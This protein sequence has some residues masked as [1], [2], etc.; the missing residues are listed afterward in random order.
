MTLRGKR[1]DRG[2]REKDAKSAHSGAIS[3]TED[4]P[5]RRPAGSGG[6][7]AGRENLLAM[8]AAERYNRYLSSLL[9]A[10]VPAG[11]AGA[12]VLDFGAGLGLFARRLREEGLEVECLEP[13]DEYRA[14]LAADGFAVRTDLASLGPG[15]DLIYAV[16]VLEHAE[17][18]ERAFRALAERLSPGGRLLV[19]VP[20]FALLFSGM[21]RAVGH[22]RRYRAGTLRRYA[23]GAGLAVSVCRY[24]DPLGFPTALLYRV[25]GR[26]SGVLSSDSLRLYDQ[27]VFRW[28]ARLEPLTGRFFGKNLLL[29]AHKR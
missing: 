26:K 21:D 24:C 28:S 12:R 5:S 2:G 16:N 13:D 15:Y 9:L 25:A 18:D 4:A 22:H 1:R 17:D 3:A 20:A 8:N 7:Y 23:A 11:T 6:A 14:L 19:Y 29:V 10:A 27:T